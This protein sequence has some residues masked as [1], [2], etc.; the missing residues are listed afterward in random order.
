MINN[1]NLSTSVS[2]FSHVNYDKIVFPANDT[3]CFQ[4]WQFILI[5]TRWWILIKEKVK[6]WEIPPT[7]MVFQFIRDLIEKRTIYIYF[8]EH[9][10]LLIYKASKK[11]M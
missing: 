2:T 3:A 4:N 1:S 8:H 11:F 10:I 7:V 9:I 5:K 6:K